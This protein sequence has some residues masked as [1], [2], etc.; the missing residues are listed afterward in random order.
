MSE[1][2]LGKLNSGLENFS[3]N[4]S[5]GTLTLKD[6]YGNTISPENPVRIEL[7]H[8]DGTIKVY[9]IRE[10]FTFRDDNNATKSDFLNAGSTD[11]ME[12]G[13]T[14]ATAWGNPYPVCIGWLHNG[15]TAYPAFSL[16][17]RFRSS[18]ASS[19]IGYKQV[20]ASVP[21]DSN[22]VAWTSTD[23]T[24]S[25]SN[26]M[27]VPF[28]TCTMT[29]SSAEDWT[30][31]VS[32]TSGDGV[33][34]EALDY[35][36]GVREYTMPTATMGAGTGSYFAGG[37]V[38]TN[39]YYLFSITRKTS[40]L[41]GRFF[42]QLDGGTDGSGASDLRLS[43]PTKV[44]SVTFDTIRGAGSFYAFG[45][46]TITSGVVGYLG[47]APSATYFFFRYLDSAATPQSVTNGMFT[48]GS[49]EVSGTYEVKVFS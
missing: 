7:R 30:L 6:S 5:S 41:K 32:V 43:I 46:T 9:Y 3:L 39:Q 27:F 20:K 26:S 36:W 38:F 24:S 44:S 45:A 15:T 48:N 10:E 19:N 16:D 12:F 22:I 42:L 49:R 31:T 37:I 8:T 4:L 40:T 11:G 28:A 33:G 21:S 34:Q 35:N 1:L 2:T 14:A 23:I 47:T 29:M 13:K 25:H 17:P 18:G